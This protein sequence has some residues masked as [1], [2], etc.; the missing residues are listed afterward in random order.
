VL[1]DLITRHI[2][3]YL[4]PNDDK[5]D[6]KGIEYHTIPPDTVCGGINH[7]LENMVEDYVLF[8]SGPMALL[9]SESHNFI[10][11]SIKSS[12]DFATPNTSTFSG[13]YGTTI[14]DHDSDKLTFTASFKLL[15][16]SASFDT[17]ILNPGIFLANRT[18]LLSLG[19][20][21]KAMS[22][23]TETIIGLSVNI[24]M[25]GHHI[26]FFD[27][28]VS[29]NDHTGLN[30][31]EDNKEYLTNLL[32]IG[33]TT[34]HINVSN[35]ISKR[36]KITDSVMTIDEYLEQ[37]SQCIIQDRNFRRKFSGKTVA[38]LYPGI[39]LDDLR[40]QNIYLYD[41]VIGV[42]FAGR[43]F[44]CDMVFTQELHILSDLSTV[45]DK[46]TIIA[47]DQIYDRMQN[48]YVNL[49]DVTDK[50]SIINTTSANYNL[51]GHSPYFIDSDPLVCLTHFL[52]SAKPRLVQILGADFK[53]LN[54]R[55]HINNHY[56]NGG[57]VKPNENLTRDADLKT[58]KNLEAIGR[59]A[60][61]LNVKVMRNYNV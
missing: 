30:Y 4:R 20:F 5:V 26:Y 58:I 31:N 10:K 35:N 29:E 41:Y 33:D 7:L 52:V 40:P 53:W 21:D 17:T 27:G 56:Y 43:I 44:K 50:V 25:S 1:G 28:I 16:Q 47:T 57:F 59:L 23:S 46:D 15:K 48:K 49:R 54:G 32:G 45:Y 8:L 3:I 22:Y 18:S 14:E 24:V 13:F 6:L 34:K 60:D 38:I 36:N 19:G 11:Y 55:S 61:T 51:E 37:N 9:A 2:V 12:Y 39:S 42:D